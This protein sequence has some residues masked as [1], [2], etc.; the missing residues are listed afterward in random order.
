M[1]IAACQ[2]SQTAALQVR[3]VPRER[4]VV[5]VDVVEVMDDE[6]VHRGQR[7]PLKGLL[8]AA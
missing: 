2:G 6:R 7:E 1:Q 3:E 5:V 8:V 4:G